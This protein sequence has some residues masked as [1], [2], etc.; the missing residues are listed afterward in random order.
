MALTGEQWTQ[1]TVGWACEPGFDP[2]VVQQA[3]NIVDPWI[4]LDFQQVPYGAQ[5]MT[6]AWG[7][8]DGPG[9]TIGRCTWHYRPED[10]SIIDARIVLDTED[11]DDMNIVAVTLHEELHGVGLGHDGDWWSVMYPENHGTLQLHN[12]NIADLQGLYGPDSGNNFLNGSNFDDTILGGAGNDTI[13]GNAGHDAIQGGT[14]NDRI[15]GGDHNDQLWGQNG[16]DSLVGGNGNDV[17]GGGAGND[18][19]DG[20]AGDDVLY[21]GDGTDTGYAGAGDDTIYGNGTGEKVI[22]AGDGNDV[23]N[24]QN[25]HADTVFGGGGYDVVEAQDPNDVIYLGDQSLDMLA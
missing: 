9:G 12:N 25:G 24:V 7:E 11:A 18:T 23:I 8:I 19:L 4:E 22:F 5:E 10:H 15:N 13:L 1:T 17:L 16:A 14:G 3:L 21:F 2:A 6:F 20:G